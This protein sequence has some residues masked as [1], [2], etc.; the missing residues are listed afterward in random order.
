MCSIL[1]TKMQSLVVTRSASRRIR[2]WQVCVCAFIPIY[3][4]FGLITGTVH[5]Y[6][7]ALLALLPLA[8]FFPDGTRGFLIDWSPMIAFWLIYDRLRLVQ[9]FLFHRVAVDTPY[10][11]ELA[12]FGWAGGGS[13]PA[14]AWRLWLAGESGF[15]GSLLSGGAQL[16]YLSHI[17]FVP[18]VMLCFWIKGRDCSK[19]RAKFLKHLTAFTI[20][21][22]IGLVTYLALPVAPPWWVSLHATSQPTAQLMV[23][24]NIRAAM[25]GSLVQGLI[26]N[27]AQWF[28]AVPSLHGA[29]PVLLLLLWLRQA[30]RRWIALL[31]F[32]GLTMWAATVVL[33]QHYIIDLLAGAGTAV[34]AWAIERVWSSRRV[35]YREAPKGNDERAK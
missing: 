11:L 13:V 10:Q 15:I 30:K 6:H 22:F 12:L 20:L 16:I 25:D 32:Y 31:A 8:I 33:N 3:L 23:Q 4:A 18:V 5:P 27:A 19:T 24:T 29:Y 21:N 7:W 9:P 17:F 34:I 2:T 28:A 1:Q 14:H 35:R 26:G